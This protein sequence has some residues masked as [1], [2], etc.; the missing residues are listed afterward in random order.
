MAFCLCREFVQYED[1]LLGI[2][3]EVDPICIYSDRSQIEHCRNMRLGPQ[4]C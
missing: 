4:F 1:N 3:A 2:F